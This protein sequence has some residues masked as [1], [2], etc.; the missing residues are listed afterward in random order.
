MV[1]FL[2]WVVAGTVLVVAAMWLFQ[3]RLIYLPTRRVPPVADVAGGWQE[4]VLD[5]ADGLTLYGWFVSPQPEEPVVVVFNGNA[6]NRSDRVPL[7]NGLAGEGFG[8]MLV[9]YRG[10]GGNPGHPTES[11]LARDARAALRWV[12][13]NAPGHS[14]VYF[15]ESL[16]AAVAI[17]LAVAEPPDALVLRSPFASLAAVGAFHYRFLP[18]RIML[19]DQFPSLDRIRM[20]AAPILVIAGSS[21]SI[22][23]IDQSRAIYDAA[24]HPKTW[25]VVDGADHNDPPLTSGPELIEATTQF[26]AEIIP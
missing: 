22:I 12:R 19:W 21:D 1:R 6:G 15:G 20:V 11:G 10:Y 8:V 9:D 14:V 17:E 23:P 13:D 2:V 3:R 26:L 25:V 7:G 18:V 5:T 16:G 4:V 24:P